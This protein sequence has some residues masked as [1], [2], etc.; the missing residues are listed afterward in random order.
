MCALTSL[1]H[2]R[3]CEAIEKSQLRLWE[4]EYSSQEVTDCVTLEIDPAKLEHGVLK[5]RI[6]F[7]QGIHIVKDL[8]A[9]RQSILD[10]PL[11]I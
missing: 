3:I 11:Y 1:F 5:L 7:T 2:P 4:R 6:D 10:D 9:V 8:Y